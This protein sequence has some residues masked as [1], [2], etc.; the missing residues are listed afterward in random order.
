MEQE[1]VENKKLL[2]DLGEELAA[3]VLRAENYEILEMKYRCKVGEIDIV[4]RRGDVIVFV[5]VKTRQSD[6]MG[7]PREAVSSTKQQRI[8]A[9]ALDYTSR[10]K[11]T[12]KYMDFQVIEITVNQI[13]RAF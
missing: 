12:W 4:A 1:R 8:R 9:A 5:E 10:I 11:E 2:G 13:T 3:E 6:I 7:L